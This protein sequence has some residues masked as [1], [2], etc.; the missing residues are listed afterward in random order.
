M[1]CLI[2][3]TL[4]FYNFLGDFEWEIQ[5]DVTEMGTSLMINDAIDEGSLEV[6]ALPSLDTISNDTGLQIAV[7]TSLPALPQ[8]N[9][10][11]CFCIFI[12]FK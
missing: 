9:G 4:I 12:Y 5:G 3:I 7:N 10:K 2:I 11:F 8:A 1:L 6:L